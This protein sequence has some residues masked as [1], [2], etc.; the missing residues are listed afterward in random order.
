MEYM[1]IAIFVL[2]TNKDHLCV[3]KLLVK[4]KFL[5]LVSTAQLSFGRSVFIVILFIQMLFT[6]LFNLN[7][8]KL[9]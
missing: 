4:A 1:V 5:N 6:F 9:R 2:K 8:R 7:N 3:V